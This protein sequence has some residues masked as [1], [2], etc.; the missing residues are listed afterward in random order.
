MQGENINGGSDMSEW[1][2]GLRSSFF[3]CDTN[4][5]KR[6]SVHGRTDRKNGSHWSKTN[7]K[8]RT[9][10][11][12]FVEFNAVRIILFQGLFQNILF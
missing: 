12:L 2:D 11:I 10:V 5:T 3:L 8:G 7:F 4:I 9:L 6:G 1:T